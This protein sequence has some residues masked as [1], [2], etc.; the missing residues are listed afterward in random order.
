MIKKTLGILAMF[1]VFQ[2]CKMGTSG[3][4]KN[5]KI[6]HDIRTQLGLLNNKL[7]KALINSDV[8]AVKAMMADELLEKAGGGMEKMVTAVSASLSAKDYKILDE[9]YVKNSATGIGNTVF[10][11]LSDNDY[12]VHYLALNKEMY[13]SLLL[14]NDTKNELLIT[15]VYGNYNNQW[16]INILQIGQYSLEKKTAPDFYTLA[17]KSYD[18]SYLVDAVNYATL[19]KQ[20]LKPGGDHFQYQKE[21]E[22]DGFYDKVMKEVNTKFKL[23]LTLERIGTKPRIFR[24]FPQVMSEGIFPAVFYVS[25]VNL[26]DT[27]AL[28]AENEKVKIEACKLFTGI[29]K[30][31]KAV[32]YRAFSELPDGKKEIKNYGFVDKK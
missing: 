14:P 25:S 19:A 26:K 18:K 29:E 16:K 20:C 24:I 32:L 23:P 22:I 30:D 6:D 27:I 13:V 1:L 28:K 21:E 5:E 15:V 31:K 12:I 4:F 9:Y 11:G 10:S 2:S 8:V 3:T 17:K 7:F